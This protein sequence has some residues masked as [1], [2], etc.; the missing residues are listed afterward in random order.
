MNHCEH[1]NADL[2]LTPE[3][4]HYGKYLCR[5]CRKFLGWAKHP[6]TIA[7]EKR[8]QEV[9]A[10]LEMIPMS[11]WEKG[12]VESIKKQLPKLS[13]KQQAKLDEMVIRYE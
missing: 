12:F 11:G 1:I 8:N 13:P 6:D 4:M 10:R 7:R 3:V 2:V 5:D 9:V